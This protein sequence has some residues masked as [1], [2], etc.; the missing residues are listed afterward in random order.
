MFTRILTALERE[1][2]AKYLKRGGA[3]IGHIQVLVSRANKHLPTIRND[4]ELLEKLLT[5]YNGVKK[6]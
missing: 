2:A 4:T 1:V 3:K 5:Q 6:R